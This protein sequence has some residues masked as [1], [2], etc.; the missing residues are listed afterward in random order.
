MDLVYGTVHIV[1]K[2]SFLSSLRLTLPTEQCLLH[3][4][5]LLDPTS[6]TRPFREIIASV[7]QLGLRRQ[8]DDSQSRLPTTLPSTA[9]ADYSQCLMS[10]KGLAI[11]SRSPNKDAGGSLP[12]SIVD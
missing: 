5:N 6:P 9:V 11:R 4:Q 2:R 10:L 12:W 7:E 3:H 1:R 8:E